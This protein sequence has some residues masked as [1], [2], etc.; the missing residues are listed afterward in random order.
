MKMLTVFIAI[1]SNI[2]PKKNIK[3]SLELIRT[4]PKFTLIQESSWYNTSPWG[5]T[6]Q[7]NFINLVI[8]GTTELSHRDLFKAL[9]DIENKLDRTRILQNGPRT[10][11]LDLLLYANQVIAEPDLVIPHIGLLERDFMLIPLIE[12]APSIPH[13]IHQT[14]LKDLTHLIKYRQILNRIHIKKHYYK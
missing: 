9:Q 13:P 3:H 4:I 2:E 6:Q 7:N 14:P 12:I 10:I 8:K 1:G 11:D 5:I